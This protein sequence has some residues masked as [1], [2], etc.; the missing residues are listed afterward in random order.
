M[1]IN[2]KLTG[3]D[4][5]TSRNFL[6]SSIVNTLLTDVSLRVLL[7]R[8]RTTVSPVTKLVTI[9]A[10]PVR[11]WNIETALPRSIL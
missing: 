3:S 8:I 1:I 10:W 11:W 9:L 7:G 2:K 5:F 6:N 4:H